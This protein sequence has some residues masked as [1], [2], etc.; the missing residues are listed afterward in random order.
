MVILSVSDTIENG[1]YSE[2][3]HENFSDIDLV[4]GCGDLPYYYLEFLADALNVPV[5][6]VL[7]NHAP[8]AEIHECE[9]H[10]EPR[11]ACNMHRRVI[12]KF[13]LI[14]AGLEGSLRYRPGKHQYTQAQM[15]GMVIT[16]LPLLFWNRLVH[17]RCL[18]ILITHSPPQGINDR[19]DHVHQGFTALRWL[20]RVCKPAY[21]FHGHVP[22]VSRGEAVTQFGPTKVINTHGFRRT[23]FSLSPAWTEEGI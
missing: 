16:M 5:L 4:L 15:W 17:H 14:I 6:Y 19:S 20:V 22:A 10:T 8:A 12:R 18:D 21:H 9:V 7:G 1:L 23:E 2:N 13:G 11:G 3:T